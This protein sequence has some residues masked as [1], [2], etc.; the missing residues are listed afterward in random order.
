MSQVAAVELKT[1]HGLS[2]RIEWLRDYYFRGVERAWNNE[3]SAWTTG[4]PWDVVYDE[5]SFHIVPETYAFFDPFTAS[6]VQSARAIPLPRSFWRR[7]VL[8]CP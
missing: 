1:P 7:S 6:A 4:T 2:P 8:H 5:T 3:F